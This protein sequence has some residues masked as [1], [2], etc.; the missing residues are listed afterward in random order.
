[1]RDRGSGRVPII[2]VDHGLD[3]I[4]RENL[5]RGRE[6]LI[7]QCMRVLA[8]EKWARD[9]MAAAVRANGLSDRQNVRLVERATE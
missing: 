5:Q 3:A 9:A 6:G 8:D 7:G 2:P 4:R 1:M